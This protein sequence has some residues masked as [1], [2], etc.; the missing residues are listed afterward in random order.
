MSLM[1]SEENNEIVSVS[2]K[3]LDDDIG[4]LSKI[5]KQSQ[6]RVSNEMIL[7]CMFSC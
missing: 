7:I 1:I 3:D 4:S 5:T 2:S 6:A